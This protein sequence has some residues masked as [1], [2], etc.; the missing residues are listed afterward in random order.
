MKI[1]DYASKLKKGE[2]K[3]EEIPSGLRG[4]VNRIVLDS[5]IDLES[6][7]DRGLRTKN[8]GGMVPTRIRKARST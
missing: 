8:F 2:I 4:A 7:T 1:L 3:A 5:A 6:Y